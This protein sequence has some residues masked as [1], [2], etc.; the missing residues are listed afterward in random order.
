MLTESKLWIRRTKVRSIFNTVAA[1]SLLLPSRISDRWLNSDLRTNVQRMI[2]VFVWASRQY[3]VWLSIPIRSTTTAVRLCAV[4][5][6]GTPMDAVGLD[7]QRP[8]GIAWNRLLLVSLNFHSY[9]LQLFRWT[10][11]TFRTLCLAAMAASAAAFAPSHLVGSYNANFP[12]N[13]Q[14]EWW[15]QSEDTV[16]TFSTSST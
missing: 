2:C 7:T 13:H 3:V 12:W 10:N 1:Q 9:R 4:L 16:D 14:E 15:L 8:P 6:N 11:M 5:P